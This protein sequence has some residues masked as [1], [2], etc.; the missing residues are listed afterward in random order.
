MHRF[1]AQRVDT[2]YEHLID[3]GLLTQG[4]DFRRE[5]LMA[6]FDIL[7]LSSIEPIDHVLQGHGLARKAPGLGTALHHC[8][9]FGFQG[10]ELSEVSQSLLVERG[11]FCKGQPSKGGAF[12]VQRLLER[13]AVGFFTR[14][15]IENRCGG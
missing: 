13:I 5:P 3:G 8:R 10:L 7:L 11:E 6:P 9:A 14:E 1:A 4:S 15:D 12:L 2:G